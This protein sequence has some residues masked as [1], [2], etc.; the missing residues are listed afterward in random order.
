MIE[1]G[2]QW[3]DVDPF[4]SPVQF[5]DS[6][7]QGLSRVGVLEIT[8]TDTAALTGSSSS[9]QA[10]RYGAK[11]IVDVYAHDDAVRLLLATVATA[12]A[13]LDKAITP[14]L[15]LFDGHHVR[16]SCLVK[17]SRTGQQDWRE[18]RMENSRG[19]RPVSIC[20]A[21]NT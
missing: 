11:G 9:S 19:R 6:A 16:I 12:A 7:L 17:T 21:P 2:Y 1:T 18:Y 14:L 13:R 15:A 10:R 8:A 4:G 20:S 3:I 5:L